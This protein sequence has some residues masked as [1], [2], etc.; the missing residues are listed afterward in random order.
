MSD[1]SPPPPPPPP[2]SPG[3]SFRSHGTLFLAWL[4]EI[5]WLQKKKKTLPEDLK[6]FQR[7][8]HDT[9]NEFTAKCYSI[10]Q[11][12]TNNKVIAS[13]YTNDAKI[14]YLAWRSV[15]SSL[16]AKSL[17]TSQAGHSLLLS[18]AC[19]H[20]VLSSGLMPVKRPDFP[21]FHNP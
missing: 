17:H 1:S 21:N 3:D 13:N 4:F 19:K 7:K 12:I 20:P 10:E 9:S 15:K 6:R 8:L 5:K 18:A 2:P 16:R 14:S 11:C